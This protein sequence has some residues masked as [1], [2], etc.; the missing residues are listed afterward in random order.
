MAFCPNLP[1]AAYQP[2]PGSVPGAEPTVEQTLQPLDMAE[3]QM[4]LG[5]LLGR[6]HYT[7]LGQY[8]HRIGHSFDRDARIHRALDAFQAE[9]EAIEHTIDARNRSRYRAYPYLKPSLI[10]QS[11]NI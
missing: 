2:P 6:T 10:P 5:T 3:L 8:P 9:L 4:V 7:R 11:I 1:L